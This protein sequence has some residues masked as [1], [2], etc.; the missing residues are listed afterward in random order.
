M[1][2]IVQKPVTWTQ[3]LA[4]ADATRRGLSYGHGESVKECRKPT[5]TSVV[6]GGL[7]KLQEFST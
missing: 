4:E 1:A 2:T 7:K 5:N 6:Y 3:G